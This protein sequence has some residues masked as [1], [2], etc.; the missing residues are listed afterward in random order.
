MVHTADRELGRLVGD[1]AVRQATAEDSVDGV[2]PGC[3][4][5]PASAE[6]LAAVLAWCSAERRSVIVR[7]GGTKMDWGRPAAAADV[8]VSMRGLARIVRHEPGDLTVTSEGGAAIADLNHELARHRQ[9]LPLDVRS[10]RSTI[11]GAVATNESGPLRHKYGA[12]RDQLIGVRLALADGR[13]ASAGGNVVKN[14]AGYD[15]G[16][17]MAGSFGSLAVIVHATFKLAPVPTDQVSLICSFVDAVSAAR[18]AAAVSESQLDPVVVD[19]DSIGSQTPQSGRCRLMIRFGGAAAAV[20]EELSAAQQLM[21]PFGPATREQLRGDTDA[22]FWQDYA[23]GIW[24]RRG[25]IVKASWLPACL[26]EVCGLVDQLRGLGIGETEFTARAAVG[27]GLIRLEGDV[28]AQVA[29]IARL[30]EPHQPTRHVV[31]VRAAAEVKARLDVW[32]TP[33]SAASV[34]RAV[35]KS[36][37]PAGILNGQRGPV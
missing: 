8:V 28:G 20:V 18:A 29:A 34:L 30:R 14:V 10:D 2:R 17:L 6:A 22:A 35:K 36:L 32:G 33:S 31:V 7:G 11:G 24:S 26:S 37:D 12:P 3:V 4:V 21:A 25:A 15:L 27:T 23:G 1:A 19:F 16:K 9:W 5:E 13:M